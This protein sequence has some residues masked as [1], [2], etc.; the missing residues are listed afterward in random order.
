[1]RKCGISGWSFDLPDGASCRD[2]WR[3][4]ANWIRKIF[5]S[6]I[7]ASHLRSR[8]VAFAYFNHAVGLPCRQSSVC[9]LSEL[10]AARAGLIRGSGATKLADGIIKLFCEFEAVLQLKS[11]FSRVPSHSNISDGLSRLDFRLLLSLG[12]LKVDVPWGEI[13]SKV[14][15]RLSWMG[16]WMA[17]RGRMLPICCVEK[18]WPCVRLQLTQ[19][20]QFSKVVFVLVVKFS[21]RTSSS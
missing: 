17:G 16:R 1:M 3:Q 14:S 7:F 9:L 8:I 6:R 21:R 18:D 2:V 4:I 10:D 15:S 11:W 19:S 5:L 13:A 12:C 20:F